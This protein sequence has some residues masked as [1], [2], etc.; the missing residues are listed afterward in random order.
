MPGHA[1]KPV[2]A[3]E[4]IDSMTSCAVSPA[5]PG[6]RAVARSQRRGAADNVAALA[7]PTGGSSRPNPM[8]IDNVPVISGIADVSN[9]GALST[10]ERCYLELGSVLL[11]IL[12]PRTRLHKGDVT[13][14]FGSADMVRRSPITAATVPRCKG[15]MAVERDGDVA[16]RCV[17]SRNKRKLYGS[18]G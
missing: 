18:R 7:A 8:N 9:V 4:H 11:W 15:D 2:Y 6:P 13:S 10:T 12:N 14:L 5:R 1:A 3:A 17:P 16:I